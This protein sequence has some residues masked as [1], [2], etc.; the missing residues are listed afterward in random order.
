MK[1]TKTKTKAI[2]VGG[3]IGGLATAIALDKVG[4][5]YV[6][7]EQSSHI[8]EIGASIAL[9]NNGIHCLSELGVDDLFRKKAI[10]T[11]KTTVQDYQD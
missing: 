1:K 2:I 8:S 11:E 3:G 7:L 10:F 9:W 4:W 5:D 6:V